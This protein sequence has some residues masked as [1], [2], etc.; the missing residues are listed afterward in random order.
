MSTKMWVTIT[1]W[2]SVILFTV[3]NSKAVSRPTNVTASEQSANIFE[4]VIPEETPIGTFV[5]NLLD[6]MSVDISHPASPSRPR[7]AFLTQPE[8]V[9]QRRLFSLDERTGV[10]RTLAVIDRESLCPLC[11]GSSILD[12]PCIWNFD[13]VVLPASGHMKIVKVKVQVS[14]VNDNPPL[15]PTAKIVYEMSES[16]EVGTGFTIPSA[17]DQDCGTNGVQRWEFGYQYQYEYKLFCIKN[18]TVVK[19]VGV[20]N[21]KKW[22]CNSYFRFLI[23]QQIENVKLQTNESLKHSHRIIPTRQCIFFSR[24]S[25]VISLLTT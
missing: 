19:H 7:F 17:V 14:D 18:Q 13:V 10:I 21:I 6:G 15:F 22:I 9:D 11:G 23:Y 25:R 1:Y 24:Y 2:T 16:S 8:S 4:Y 20:F 12:H 3:Q 5:G